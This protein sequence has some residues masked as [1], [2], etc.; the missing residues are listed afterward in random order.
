MQVNP[1]I[2]AGLSRGCHGRNCGKACVR[3]GTSEAASARGE[4]LYRGEVPEH[5]SKRPNLQHEPVEV[6]VTNLRH[7][8]QDFTLEKNGFR[9]ASFHVPAEIDRVNN[10]CWMPYYAGGKYVCS[11]FW[12]ADGVLKL[13]LAP[14]CRH[15]HKAL[16]HNL[17]STVLRRYIFP[18]KGPRRADET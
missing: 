14:E 10:F 18:A 3:S 16:A 4:S 8:K 12:L 17:W 2:S 9:L 6:E 1:S 15:C 7:A 11:H 13:S 5:V